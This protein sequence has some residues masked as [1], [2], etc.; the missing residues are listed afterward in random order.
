[1][2]VRVETIRR[3]VV[4]GLLACAPM[5][6]RAA[7][8]DEPTLFVAS[9][10]GGIATE[11]LSDGVVLAGSSAPDGNALALAGEDRMIRL[12][13][14]ATG[15]V[16]TLKGHDDVVAGLAFA[17]DGKTLASGGY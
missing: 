6:G 5:S 1:M 13:E 9:P 14:P 3:L 10:A 4:V 12:V 7:S 15:R 16:R 2:S 8:G 11:I 17:P